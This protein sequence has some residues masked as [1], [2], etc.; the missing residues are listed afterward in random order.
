MGIQGRRFK[1]VGGGAVR[2]A[3]AWGPIAGRGAGLGAR[4]GGRGGRELARDPAVRPRPHPPAASL[5]P[6]ARGKA[7]GEGVPGS[8][9]PSG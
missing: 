4:P 5:R 3:L 1:A 2:S 8:R 7:G 9:K 6:G